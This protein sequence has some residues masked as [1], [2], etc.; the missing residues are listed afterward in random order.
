MHVV[1]EFR[2]TA[3][4]ALSIVRLVL[5]KEEIADR[6]RAEVPGV[7]VTVVD[8][9]TI[10]HKE[11][12]R[13]QFL[14]TRVCLPHIVYNAYATYIHI[15]SRL[16][17]HEIEVLGALICNVVLRIWL[18]TTQVALVH[19]AGV[20]VSMHGGGAFQI[21]NAAVGTPH[22]CAML[23]LFPDKNAEG[24]FPGIRTIGNIA[25]HMGIHYARYDPP[26]GSTTNKGT[27]LNA[28]HVVSYIRDAV[29][30]VR[31]GP[32][33]MHHSTSRTDIDFMLE[34]MFDDFPE[35]KTLH[36]APQM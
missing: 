13:W 21:F 12:V 1:L 26:V 15:K 20:F 25:R 10:S 7:N 6:I 8:L 14:L 24:D 5:N 35:V 16:V 36:H 11:Q 33:R 18:N 28:T 31:S 32:A 19:S 22:C 4:N 3:K 23:E 9:G 17:Y 30:K 29:E 2:S 27:T 34:R